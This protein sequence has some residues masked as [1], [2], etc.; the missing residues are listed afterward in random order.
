MGEECYR[1]YSSPKISRAFTKN[2][3][4][5]GKLQRQ[6]N[7][8]DKQRRR[9]LLALTNSSVRSAVTKDSKISAQLDK[10]KVPRFSKLVKER[11]RDINGNSGLT[12]ELF[13]TRSVIEPRLVNTEQDG[14]G[15]SDAYNDE[16]EGQPLKDGFV[17][18]SPVLYR[19][20]SLSVSWDLRPHSEGDMEGLFVDSKTI[21]MKIK[22]NRYASFVQL[23]LFG[24]QISNAPSIRIRIVLIRK[25]FSSGL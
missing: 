5:D 21:T 7:D 17:I 18:S 8:I 13:D 24:S 22:G 15:V 2:L 6:L 4:L 14:D 19:D 10:L 16:D 11:S 20:N 1:C 12:N 3:D 23:T 9:K 25:F